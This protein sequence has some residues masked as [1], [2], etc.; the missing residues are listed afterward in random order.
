MIEG[1]GPAAAIALYL[2]AEHLVCQDSALQE[3]FVVS[4]QPS[5]Q[6]G[7]ENKATKE[8]DC[9]STRLSVSIAA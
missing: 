5:A 3:Q 2:L 1:N 9:D 8:A 7:K 4:K 6:K